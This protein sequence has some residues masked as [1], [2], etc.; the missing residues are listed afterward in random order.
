[1]EGTLQQHVA[2]VEPL[3]DAHGGGAGDRL[4]V[5][6]R[7]LDGSRAA[8]FGQQGGMQVEVAPSRQV[9]HPLGNDAAVGDH[10]DG[11]RA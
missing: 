2:G 10:D 1:M 9:Q 5:G 8:V 7:P 6:H 3:V 11:I 4:A